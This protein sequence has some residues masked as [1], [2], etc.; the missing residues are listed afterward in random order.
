MEDDQS[1]DQ[2]TIEK[3]EQAKRDDDQPEGG[4]GQSS[5]R[6]YE[7]TFCER[8]FSNAQAL[9]GHMNIH[10]KD[11]AKLKQ[12]TKVMYSS[13]IP[14]H[15]SLW[16]MN[17][18]KPAFCNWTLSKQQQDA[19][20]TRDNDEAGRA[21]EIRQLP[22]FAETPSS[23]SNNIETL[24]GQVHGETGHAAASS[25]GSEILDLE[26]RLGHQ[27]PHQDSASSRATGT[28]KFF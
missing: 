8:G 28:R 18:P 19:S 23:L 3:P 24:D 25:T 17:Q 21:I 14:T 12:S 4:G 15:N 11:K 16:P 22:L 6:S 1:D 20:N 7:C 13:N 26:L 27:P 5:V 2:T 9:G 10:R